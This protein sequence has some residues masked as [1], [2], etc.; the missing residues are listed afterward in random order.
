MNSSVITTVKVGSKRTLKKKNKKSEVKIVLQLT[1]WVA[2]IL[3]N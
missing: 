1:K 2:E 3:I